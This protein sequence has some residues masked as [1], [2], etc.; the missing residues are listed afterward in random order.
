[1]AIAVGRS[2]ESPNVVPEAMLMA[3]MVG[4]GELLSNE[5]LKDVEIAPH[6]PE[7]LKGAK[8]SDGLAY[9]TVVLHDHPVAP[10]Q[11]LS[12]D[13]IAEEERLRTAVSMLQKQKGIHPNGYLHQN[14]KNR[15]HV[16]YQK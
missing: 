8:F 6:K 16:H 13:P 1:M 12:D 7:R 2:A 14:G 11:L 5:A 15:R 4:A 9:G 10:E 3:E